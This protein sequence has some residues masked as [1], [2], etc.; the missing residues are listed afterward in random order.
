MKIDAIRGAVLTETALVLTATLGVIFGI[1][2]LGMI[3]FLQLTCDGAAFI[4]AHEYSLGNTSTYV[5]TTAKVFPQA[6]PTPVVDT[7]LPTT[8]NATTVNVDYGSTGSV[9]TRH[10]GVSLIDGSHLQVTVHKAAPSGL[11][12]VGGAA[13]SDIDI[14]GSAIEPESLVANSNYDVAGAGYAAPSTQVT[15]S[16]TN[17]ANLGLYYISQHR[18]LTCISSALASTGGFGQT[19]PDNSGYSYAQGPNQLRSLG[20]AEFLD[21]DNWNRATLGV[22]PGTSTSSG[23]TF[24]EMLCHQQMY[25]N[26]AAV[27]GSA[28]TAAA[29][30]KINILTVG[31]TGQ[32]GV[33]GK[34]YSWDVTFRTDSYGT[35]GFSTYM[36]VP[37]TPAANCP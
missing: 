21:F 8:S 9:Y 5:T 33:I 1:V 10:G 13:L 34:I 31:T 22:G 30:P 25:A 28:A 2:Q 20:T 37:L 11:L 32:Y 35:G 27:F 36:S 18:L 14:H 24:G 7:N 29:M 23:Y 12:G 17:P 4:A 26:A 15:F 3:G 6:G 19:C 16:A